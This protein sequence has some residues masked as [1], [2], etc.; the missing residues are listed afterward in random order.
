MLGSA[1]SNRI[2][3]A[4]LQVIVGVVDH[5]QQARDAVLAPR[6]H[7]EDDVV[8]VEPGDRRR[9]AA[10][11][12]PRGARLPRPQPVLRR[13]AGGRARPGHRRALGRRRSAARRRRGGCVRRGR[14]RGGARGARRAGASRRG[15]GSEA[16]DL[17]LVTR[18]GD[19]P[20]ARL[21]LRVTDD[22]RASCNGRP[23][24]DITSAQLITARETERDL[25]PSRRRRSCAWRPG[26]SRSSPTACA[27]RTAAWPGATTRARQP[28]VLFKLAQLTRDVAK[29]PCHLAR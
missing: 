28:P 16:R 26:P 25:E 24:V 7:F 27:P 4:I 13:R 14:A 12:R 3:S 8:Y 18:S 19:V 20:G 15:C 17:F 22:G 5:G 23:L 9:R 21:T 29:G 11:R 10:R 6:A 1:G 2:R